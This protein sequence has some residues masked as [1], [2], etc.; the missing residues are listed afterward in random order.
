MPGLLAHM[1]LI[2]ELVRE[3]P[4]LFSSAD[5][6]Y[7]VQG[8]TFPDIYYI[9][10]LKSITNKPNFSKYIHEVGEDCDYAKILIQ[11][12]KNKQER[13]FAIGFLSHMILDRNVHGYLK[14]EGIYADIKH[15]VSEYYLETK[16]HSQKVPIPIFPNVLIKDCLKL[17]RPK[18]YD[19]YKKRLKISIRGLL[20]YEFVNTFI[21]NKIINGR[22][23]KENKKTKWSLL[24]L[25]FKFARLSKYKKMGYDYTQLLNPD[26]SIKNKYLEDMYKEYQKSKKELVNL[27]IEQELNVVDYTT[28]QT[29]IN[30]FI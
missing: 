14:K 6:K 5:I 23:R 13:L 21:V 24:N 17:Y 11:K 9:T 7:L 27:I 1:T 3:N 15:M 26:I 16:F 19:V 20:F 2:K 10:E 8:A 22:Y 4:K 30:D 29:E 12:S 28:H 18:D 25:P